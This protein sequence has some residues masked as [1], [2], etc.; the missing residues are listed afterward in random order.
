MV[1]IVDG[2]WSEW[3]DVSGCSSTC[4]EGMKLLLRSCIEPRRS[5]GGKFCDGLGL[6]Y[7]PCNVNAC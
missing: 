1:Y 7:V 4:G 5:C 2:G 6:Q 3:K